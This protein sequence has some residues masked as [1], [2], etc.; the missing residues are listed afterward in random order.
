MSEAHPDEHDR[1]VQEEDA[2]P[3]R[4]VLLVL[5]ALVILSIGCILYAAVLF[6][7]SERTLDAGMRGRIPARAPDEAGPIP[8]DRRLL[9]EK[10]RFVDEWRAP[11][12]ER[13]GR[14]G[15][16]DRER[17]VVHMPIEKAMEL[18]AKEGGR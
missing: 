12:F 9:R 18:V 7:S 13:L 8:P 15:W 11:Q 16:V 14:W 5:L 4:R 10:R 1:P 2:L 17:G 6:R 3:T